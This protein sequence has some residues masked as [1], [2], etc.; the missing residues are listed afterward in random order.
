MKGKEGETM[1]HLWVGG[2]ISYSFI[3]ILSSVLDLLA[4]GSQRVLLRQA[5]IRLEL[6]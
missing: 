4:G 5:K 3:A 1:S 6:E 2:R